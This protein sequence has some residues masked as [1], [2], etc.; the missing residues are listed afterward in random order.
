NSCIQFLPTIDG[1]EL[2]TVESLQAPDGALH[3]VQQAMVEQHASQ[4]GFCTPG[5]VMSLF[6]LYETTHQASRDEVTDTIAGNLC[7]CTGYGPILDAAQ[8]MYRIGARSSRNGS[9]SPASAASL[10]A[11][12]ALQRDRMLA[13]EDA[14]HTYFAPVTLAE[15]ADL[16][17][18]H[19]NATLLAGGTDVGLWVTKLLQD[20]P[21]MI[22][23]GNVAELKGITATSDYLEIGAGVSWSDAFAPLTEHFPQ[24]TE[25][26]RRF[27]SPPI[28]NAATIGGNIA[29]GSPVG[30]SMPALLAL[31]ARLRL[32]R[33]ERTRELGLDEFYLGYRCNALEPGE[34]LEAVR[35]PL[36]APTS[37][38]ASYKLSKRFDQD[39]AAVCAAF[40]IDVQGGR[41]QAARVAYGGM[42]AVPARARRCEEALTGEPWS[43]ASVARAMEALA[44]D[45][46]PISDMRANAEYRAT[47][48][49]TLLYRFALETLDAAVATRVRDFGRR[50]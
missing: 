37:H 39:I 24:L 40:W 23:L 32:R 11:L 33:G 34:F 6:A 49:R 5:F 4:C 14:A 3:P 38:F 28:R 26:L 22:Y 1:K 12:R 16:R 9:L 17:A 29:N 50:R 30:D 35:I 43:R 46:A 15:L 20:L 2:I 44:E 47:T 21:V 41:V 27:A 31:G 18:A 36:L 19:P 25:L 42:A 7:R 48:A 10:S 45:Y 8:A 13:I